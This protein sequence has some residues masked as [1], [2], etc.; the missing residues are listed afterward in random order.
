MLCAR[1]G[2]HTHVAFQ[3]CFNLV[4]WVE[5]I[6]EP[7]PM[8][9]WRGI[10]CNIGWAE[11]APAMTIFRVSPGKIFLGTNI[12]CDFVN[13]TVVRDWLLSKDSKSWTQSWQL[14]VSAIADS[15]WLIGYMPE[16]DKEPP[17]KEHKQQGKQPAGAA[18]AQPAT[19]APANFAN[20]KAH[21]T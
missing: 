20:P 1:Q 9:P 4:R 6:Q 15:N 17:A 19:P 13:G 21:S 3:L 5:L 18:P 2:C 8:S 14:V 16:K 12:R 10:L 11:A 7:V